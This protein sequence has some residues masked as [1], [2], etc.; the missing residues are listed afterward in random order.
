MRNLRLVGL[1]AALGVA[2]A[3]CGGSAPPG[4]TGQEG[5]QQGGTIKIGSIHPLTGPLAFDGQQMAKAGKFAAERI[6]AQ[7]GIKSLDGAKLQVLDADSKGEPEVGQSEAQRLIQEG[8]AA[9]VGPYQSAVAS[10]VAAVAERNR[11]PFLIDVA[12]ADSILEQGYT[13]TFRIQPNASSMGTKGADYL[14]EL[15]EAS[16]TPIRSV[17]VL[18]EQ[19]DFGKSVL[20]AFKARAEGSGMKVGP[21]ISYDAVNVSDLT[22]EITQ[23]KAEG[24]DALVVTGYYRDGVLAAKAISSVRPDVKVVFGIA[25]GA[26]DLPQFTS[27]AGKAGEGFFDANYHFNA[28]DPEMRKL[29]AD[30]KAKYGE[31]IRTSSVL[32]YEAVR[33]IA[34]G[35]EKAGTRDPQQLREAISGLS[36]DTLM[37]YPGP[38][39]FDKTG[40]NTSATPIVMQVQGGTVRQVFPKEFAEAE[41]RFPA[42]PAR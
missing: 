2:L 5:D 20:A 37:A 23:V 31:D 1:L 28:R 11:V 29:A 21:E 36:L 4:T 17:A 35:L 27:D 7:G 25:N 33:V 3:A 40:Q 15:A 8:A 22:T 6:N 30:F 12:V 13:N 42:P 16:G 19:T 24:V 18:H 9:L 10:N 41:P 14:A 26:F 38:I 32:A 39:S 34:S